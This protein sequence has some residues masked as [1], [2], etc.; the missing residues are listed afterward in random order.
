M[1]A[2]LVG[3]AVAGVGVVGTLGA[4]VAAQWAVLRGKRLDA[5][6]HREQHAEQRD[7][8]V[9]QQE[10]ERKQAVYSEFNSAA[11]NYRMQLHHCV[12]ALERGGPAEVD[13]LENDRRVYREVY[14][15]AQMILPDDVLVVASEI[16]LS[17]GNSYRAVL[18]LVEYADPDAVARLHR[19]LDGP[20]S[21][22]VWLLR[23]V[24]REDLGVTTSLTDPSVRTAA[25]ASARIAQF[26]AGAGAL[27]C[28]LGGDVGA[29]S[30]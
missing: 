24:L 10:R 30:M 19:W 15:Q 16:D 27:N 4:S 6:I 23:Q 11:R 3:L 20:V 5:E 26:E 2:D 21:E 25:L 28:R 17:L 29:Q 18:C 12:M 7:E 13:Q 22:A 14:A 8:A 9:R 1:G